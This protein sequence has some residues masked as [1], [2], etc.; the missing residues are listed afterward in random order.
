MERPALKLLLED[1]DRGRVDVVVVY[2]VDRLTRSLGDFARIVEAF[3]RKGV[4][5]VSVTQQ[6]NTTSS[7]G[8]LTL[9]VLLSFA[10]FEREVTGER[11]RDKIA[12]SKAKGMWMGGRPP[13]G[14]DPPTDPTTRAL[15]VNPAEAEVVK[16]IFQRY[17]E[18]GSVHELQR[19]LEDDGV[20][21]KRS[22]SRSGV[23]RG[24]VPLGRGA[25]FHLLHNRTYLGEIVHGK[26]SYPGAHPA[27]IDAALFNEV[28][29]RLAMSLERG[30]S[31]DDNGRDPL[32][33]SGLIFDAAG[34]RM[35]P[36]HVKGPRGRI[37]RYYVSSS[38]QR[39]ARADSGR[40][41]PRRP[42]ARLLD[43]LVADCIR[44]LS[45]NF[46]IE[47]TRA[48][49]RVELHPE[50]LLLTLK[51]AALVPSSA[52]PNDAAGFL[53]ASAPPELHVHH[54][55]DEPEVRVSLPCRLRRHGVRTALIDLMGDQ[56]EIGPSLIRR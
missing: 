21:S 6:F 19:W 22:T 56:V 12:A 42:P 52:G 30:A 28:Q 47:P 27:I 23:S 7:M 49:S 54:E 14:Y 32:L 8:R 4:S 2:K 18:I 48:I 36:S 15:V 38:L 16:A 20:C 3:D 37:Y 34:E 41:Y 17:L 10:Q 9:N 35:S 1:I 45:P 50:R 24:G 46:A 40:I 29:T 39:G 25:L 26:K 33:L 5:F 44:A 55:D 31:R 43:R 13:L 53:K 11:I 51:L